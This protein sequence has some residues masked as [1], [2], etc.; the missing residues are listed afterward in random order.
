[1]PVSRDRGVAE[2][3][4]GWAAVDDAATWHE[5]EAVRAHDTG[6]HVFHRADVLRAWYDTVARAGAQ[7]PV[8]LRWSGDGA[9]VR[10]AATVAAYKGRW[11]RRRVL[12][13]AGQD[14]FGYHAPL[15]AGDASRVDWDAFWSAV[16]D[17]GCEVD[18]ALFRFV[19]A[20]MAGL[21]MAEP[22]G[23]ESPVLAL[24]G[25]ESLTA[26]LARVSPN[27]RGDVGRRLR[28]AAEQGPLSLDVFGVDD[29]EAAATEFDVRF[30]PVWRAASDAQGWGLHARPGFADYCR[31][32]VVEGVAAGW[33]HFSVLRVGG[34]PLAWHLG[35]A[36]ARR[37]YWWLPVHDAAHEGLAPGK[38]LLALLVGRL[39]DEGWHALHFQTGAQAYKRAW[40][41]SFPPLA[42]V[43]W[44][45]PS[46]KGR[47]LAAHDRIARSR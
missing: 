2:C 9:D 21:R 3:R 25:V 27:H 35:L 41:P 33:T 19:P 6:A 44:H 24:G 45:A 11:T 16:R 26:L 20:A 31:R 43:R 40:Q 10:L 29:V 30:W 34:E 15:V 38:V 17:A 4:A 47:L 36:D 32:V 13:P 14:L 12:E 37:L 5:W 1:M 28:R 18:A 7:E 46:V 22:A 23:D 42:A 8:L 39:I